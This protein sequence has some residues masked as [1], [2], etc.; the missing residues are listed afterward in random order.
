MSKQLHSVAATRGKC[1]GG[2]HNPQRKMASY[3]QIAGYLKNVHRAVP[4][5]HMWWKMPEGRVNRSKGKSC[6]IWSSGASGVCMTAGECYRGTTIG[7]SQ[8][9]SKAWGKEKR[10]PIQWGSDSIRR[11]YVQFLCQWLQSHRLVALL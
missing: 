11:P 7:K 4:K 10:K 3:F 8:T 2:T 9:Y 6:G 1:S 5:K